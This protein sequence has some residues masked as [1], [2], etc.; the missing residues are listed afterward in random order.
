MDLTPNQVVDVLRKCA[1]GNICDGC[2]LQ[3]HGAFCFG[4]LAEAA[5]KTIE[6]LQCERK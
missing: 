1:A 2:P 5:A 6:T 4:I 3:K